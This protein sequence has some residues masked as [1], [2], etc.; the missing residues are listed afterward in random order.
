MN[1]SP[2]Y[3]KS[4]GSRTAC[5]VATS[6]GAAAAIVCLVCGGIILR[7]N[8]ESLG[9]IYKQESRI[10]LEAASFAINVAITLC[11]G[12]MM[13][14]HAVSL[15]WALYREGRL[16]YNTNILLFTSSRRSGPNTWYA[17]MLALFC[18][19]LTYASSSL[20]FLNRLSADVDDAPYQVNGTAVVSLGIGLAGQAVI[21]AW[22]L[23]DISHRPILTWSS[24]R[25]N[26]TLAAVQHGYLTQQPGRCM[27][28]IHQRHQRPDK[29]QLAYPTKRQRSMFATIP[30][31]PSIVAMLWLLAAL[32]LAWA[33]TITLLVK[34]RDDTCHSSFSFAG[35]V[36]RTTIVRSHCT[37]LRS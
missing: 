5:I 35:R 7:N 33:V 9:V 24:N 37:F 31:V 23:L 27:L 6:V 8:P 12:G 15:R 13:Y 11:N 18:L 29:S 30:M 28:S 34:N 26:T 25:L 32:A 21:A 4:L 10:A 1:S 20:T 19:V 2:Q 3:D 36:K 14:V 22:C 16:E 17:N